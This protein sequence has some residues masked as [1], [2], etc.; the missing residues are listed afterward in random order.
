MRALLSF[1]PSGSAEACD[2]LL[3]LCERLA[4]DAQL[5]KL[6]GAAP[7]EPLVAWTG[8]PVP[9]DDV[10]SGLQALQATVGPRDVTYLRAEQCVLAMRGSA[11]QRGAGLQLWK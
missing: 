4:D 3:I 8:T 9:V 7:E 5:A 1:A 6:G 2:L 10:I 11:S